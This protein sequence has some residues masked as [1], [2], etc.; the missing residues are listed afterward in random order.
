M[1]AILR[2]WRWWNLMKNVQVFLDAD[3]IFCWYF[4]KSEVFEKWIFCLKQHDYFKRINITYLNKFLPRKFRQFQIVL[5]WVRKIFWSL[6]IAITLTFS[7]FESS[8]LQTTENFADQLKNVCQEYRQKIKDAPKGKVMH[9]KQESAAN[10]KELKK[11]LK[12]NPYLKG[13]LGNR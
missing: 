5:S 7:I 2:F 4:C 3:E 13:L 11:R 6:N 9:L 1:H 12:K 8:L 10:D